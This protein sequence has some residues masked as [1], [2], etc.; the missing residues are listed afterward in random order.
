MTASPIN[1]QKM[2]MERRRQA[3]LLQLMPQSPGSINPDIGPINTDKVKGQS[4]WD[5]VQAGLM[6]MPQGSEGL[7]SDADMKTARNQGL[8]SMGA[9]LLSDT[10]PKTAE[11]Y[12][13]PMASIGKAIQAGQGAGMQALGN[14]SAAMQL[15]QAKLGI[16]DSQMKLEKAKKLDPIRQS[17]IKSHPMP[18]TANKMKE[19]IDQTLPLFIEAGDDETVAKLT[20][21]YSTM[22]HNQEKEPGDWVTVPGPDG[23]PMRRYVTKGEAGQ[24]GIPEYERPYKD[25]TSSDLDYQ[26]KFQRMNGLAD[27]YRMVTKSIAQ[28][29]D[30]FRTMHAVSKDAR[31]GSPQAQIALVFSYMKTLDPSSVVRE[32]EYATAANAAGVPERVRNQYNKVLSGAFLTPE[33]VDGFLKTGRTS[34]QAWKR[35]QDRHMKTFGRRAGNWKIDPADV[36]QDY[37]EDVDINDEPSAPEKPKETPAEKARRMGL[38]Q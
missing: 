30:Q 12:I 3:T 21:I 35:Q 6:P 5:K 31:A 14:K 23:K 13:S 19:W 2:E 28:A 8:L 17:I 26:R 38:G 1:K 16:E 27:D 20:N 24:A 10:G 34:A 11:N 25:S 9:S 33:Q 29:A 15:Q 32:S 18:K 4:I 22:G 37:F 7:L 36:V